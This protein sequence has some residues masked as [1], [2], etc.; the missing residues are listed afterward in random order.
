MP[1]LGSLSL[2]D[3]LRV[4]L[5]QILCSRGSW[6]IPETGG[7]RRSSFIIICSRLSFKRLTSQR[8]ISLSANVTSIIKLLLSFFII[9][10]SSL[11][12]RQS[13]VQE[14]QQMNCCLFPNDKRWSLLQSFPSSLATINDP[15]TKVNF[16]C[17]YRETTLEEMRWERP[18]VTEADFSFRFGCSG[19]LHNAHQEIIF[20]EYADN[21]F[22]FAVA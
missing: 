19:C 4:L 21:V 2:Y 10:Q 18:H 22:H 7:K 9:T 8:I 12:N 16:P 13:L 17:N 5:V 6:K 1:K 15:F 20:N 14:D 3:P 11:T